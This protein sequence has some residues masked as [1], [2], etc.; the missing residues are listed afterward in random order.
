MFQYPETLK[1][2]KFKVVTVRDLTTGYDSSTPD[3][4]ALLP[5]SL[6]SQMIT[7]T[8]SNGFEVTLRT[9]GTEPKVKYYTELI[10]GGT[11]TNLRTLKSILNEMT[12]AVIEE[13]LQ[14]KAYGLIPRAGE[15]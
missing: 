12:K 10:D 7:F 13:M 3:N 6:S 8:F 1:K 5:S 2:G 11:D 4:K 9:S 14:P 15:K